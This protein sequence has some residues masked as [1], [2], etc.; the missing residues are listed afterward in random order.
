MTVLTI[1]AE[2][3][4]VEAIIVGEATEVAVVVLIEGMP[5]DEEELIKMTE[6]VIGLMINAE[7]ILIAVV[8]DKIMNW[9]TTC[10]V[11]SL[12][13][14]LRS[15]GNRP[16]R[17]NDH[18]DR[19]SN[20]FRGRGGYNRNNRVGGNLLYFKAFFQNENFYNFNN[21]NSNNFGSDFKNSRGFDQD[22]RNDYSGRS[23][24]NFL[25]LEFKKF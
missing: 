3:K 17:F 7:I 9:G 14:I 16:Q 24:V 6:T 4:N 22:Q 13:C 25:Y 20:N 19:F 23:G 12:K 21:D 8:G 1:K 18:D 11:D 5:T 10:L 15:L 2:T